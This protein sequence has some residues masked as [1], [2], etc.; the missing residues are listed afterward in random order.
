MDHLS[1][2]MHE[3]GTPQQV[4]QR[5]FAY[6]RLAA[7]PLPMLYQPMPDILTAV[8]NQVKGYARRPSDRV[9]HPEELP[10]SLIRPRSDA[11]A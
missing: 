3:A 5:F 4:Q 1:A 6:E 8:V 2:L 7:V 11:Q 9:V 10:A